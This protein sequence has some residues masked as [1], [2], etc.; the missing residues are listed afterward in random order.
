MMRS[1]TASPPLLVFGVADAA[2]LRIGL[3]VAAEARV[4]SPPAA[5]RPVAPMAALRLKKVRRDTSDALSWPGVTITFADSV[6]LVFTV[7]L[8]EGIQELVS[9]K[10]DDR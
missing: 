6:S 3:L 8:L 10:T 9:A 4:D 7:H 1:L 5:I 2:S